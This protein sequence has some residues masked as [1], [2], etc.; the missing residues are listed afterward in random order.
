MAATQPLEVIRHHLCSAE[1][2]PVRKSM[3]DVFST[4]KHF[5]SAGLAFEER[6]EALLGSKYVALQTIH[7]CSPLIALLMLLYLSC[8]PSC[9]LV[10]C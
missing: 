1:E 6:L 3:E 2:L 10:T 5:E 8:I 4:L 9:T 7:T